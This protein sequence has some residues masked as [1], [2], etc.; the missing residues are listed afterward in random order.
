[1]DAVAQ[2]SREL[3]EAGVTYEIEVYSGARHA[4]TVFGSDRYQARAD[5]KSWASFN[6]LLANTLGE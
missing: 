6:T 5:Q 4:F 2:L 1:M 3:E